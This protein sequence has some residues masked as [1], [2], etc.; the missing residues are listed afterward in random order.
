MRIAFIG[1]TLEGTGASINPAGV[2]GLRF[3]DEAE[4]VN[5]LVPEIRRQ[6]IEAIVVVVH[7]GALTTVGFNDK[8]CAG[9]SGPLLEVLERL[10]PAVDLIISGHTHRAYV[11]EIERNDL[12]RPLLLT[13]AGDFGTLLTDIRLTIDP[14]SGVVIAAQA[15]NRIVQGEAHQGA[16]MTDAWPIFQLH[17]KVAAHV[18]SHVDAV[19]PLTSR[20]VGRL[21]APATMARTPAGESALGALLADAQLTATQAPGEGGAEIAF[22]NTGGIRADLVPGAGGAITYGQLFAAQPFSEHVVV[23]SLNGRQIRAILEQQFANLPRRRMLQ[24]S[25]SLHYAYDLSKPAG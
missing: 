16:P 19:A 14:R 6:G 4:T 9:F 12:A 7:Q 5:A 22:V 17:P 13:S 20:I 24:V 15:D 21:S 18:A 25:G 1:L 10:D 8:S 3:L 2:A 11:C 23:M